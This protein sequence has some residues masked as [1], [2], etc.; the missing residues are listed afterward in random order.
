[1]GEVGIGKWGRLRSQRRKGRE[2]GV[3]SAGVLGGEGG[4]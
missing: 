2:N 3:E 4:G 1:M